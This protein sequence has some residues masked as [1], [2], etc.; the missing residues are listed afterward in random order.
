MQL[1]SSQFKVKFEHK[2]FMMENIK[3]LKSKLNI[4]TYNLR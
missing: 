4:H 3:K 2:I 1:P